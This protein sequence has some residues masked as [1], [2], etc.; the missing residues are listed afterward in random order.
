MIVPLLWGAVAQVGYDARAEIGDVHNRVLSAFEHLS[1]QICRSETSLRIAE[2]TYAT[3]PDG[4]GTSPL[5]AMDVLPGGRFALVHKRSAADPRLFTALVTVRLGG[6]RLLFLSS[7][8]SS[9]C[10]SAAAAAPRRIRPAGRRR[11]RSRASVRA[12]WSMSAG[13]ACT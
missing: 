10:S 11:P 8:S 12:G 7:S 2:R 13:A 4:A 1:K 6:W 9:R 5:D 3:A